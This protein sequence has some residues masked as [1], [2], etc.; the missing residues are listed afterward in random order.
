MHMETVAWK[1][2]RGTDHQSADWSGRD[3]EGTWTLCSSNVKDL[4]GIELQKL[5]SDSGLPVIPVSH[6]EK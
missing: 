4:F 3:E 2:V 5:Q 6:Y 1:S